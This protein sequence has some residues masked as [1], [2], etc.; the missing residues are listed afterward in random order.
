MMQSY[1][2]QFK[3]LPAAGT[4]HCPPQQ[5]ALFVAKPLFWIF[6]RFRIC[7]LQWLCIIDIL[8]RHA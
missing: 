5:P 4:D 1:V 7:L 8:R 2:I 6:A 3:G